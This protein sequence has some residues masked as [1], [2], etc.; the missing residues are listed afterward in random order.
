MVAS[1]LSDWDVALDPA[2][3]THLYTGIIFDTGGFKYENTMSKTHALAAQ[4]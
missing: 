2:M 3:A 4:P 1:M